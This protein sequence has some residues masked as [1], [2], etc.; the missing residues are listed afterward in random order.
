MRTKPKVAII[1]PGSFPIPST[2]SSSVE[3]VVEMQTNAL[4]TD[5]DFTIFGKKTSE[6]P[7]SEKRGNISYIRFIYRN[8]TKYLTKVISSLTKL[9]PDIIQIENRPN[10]IPLLRQRFQKTPLCLSLHST[11]FISSSR[12]AKEELISCLYQVD[13]I[14]VNSHFL[15]NYLINQTGCKTAK[16]FVNHLGV[17]TNQFQSKWSINH[18]SENENITPK[19]NLEGKRIILF[20]GRLRK[21]KGVEKIL[22]SMPSIIQAVPDTLLIIVGSAF[23]RSDRK[24]NYVDHLYRLAKEFPDHVRFLSFIP[25]EQIHVWFKAAD[26]VLVPSI[27]HEAFGLVNV[28]AMACGVPVI[29]T[30]IGGMPEV[31][32]H[33]KTGYLVNTEKLEAELAKYVIQLLNNPEKIKQLGLNC[34]NRV[35]KDFT[36]EKSASRLLRLYD[37]I[38]TEK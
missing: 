3:T 18:L 37:H 38:V 7:S 14:I 29:A 23:Y 31:I 33:G 27:A 32:E 35:Y 26:I 5:V 6:L 30:N 22:M 13:K 10:F 34:V 17:D 36:W 15:K 1:T 19:L 28:E 12:S 9:R 2:R 20:V 11:K 4:Q 16:I 24:T 8:W 21:I 25:H